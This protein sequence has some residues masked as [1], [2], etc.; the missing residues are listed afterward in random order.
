MTITINGKPF[1]REDYIDLEIKSESFEF[2]FLYRPIKEH[3]FK[4][5]VLRRSPV[6][7]IPIEQYLAEKGGLN[8]PG[9]NERE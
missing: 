6:R 9:I 4:P 1:N 8:L 7:H 5:R 2:K 3:A